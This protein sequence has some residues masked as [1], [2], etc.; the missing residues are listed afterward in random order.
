[1]ARK[2]SRLTAR[3]VASLKTP[4]RH[5]DGGN[6]Y[7][8]I[9]KTAGGL[10]KR[11]V[12]MFSLAGKQR[13]PG[14]GAFPAVNLAAARS[15]AKDMR[16][17]VDQGIDPLDQKKAASEAA[18]GRKTFAECAAS[19]IASKSSS[20]RNAKHAG[21]WETTLATHG[22]ALRDI[23]VDAIT[24]QDVLAVLTPIWQDIPET[25]SRLRGRIEAVLDFATAHGLR[26]EAN[27]AS[28]RTLQHILPKRAALSRGRHAALPYVDVPAFVAT[29]RG[30]DTIPAMAL[31]FLILTASRSGEV[32]GASWDEIDLAAKVWVIP[33]ARMK[34][35]REHRVPL[36]ARAIAI[37]EQLAAHRTCGFVFPG[38]NNQQLESTSLRRLC[39]AGITVHGFRSSFRDFLGDQTNFSRE[40]CEGCLAHSV[41]NS[42][43]RA[44]RRSDDLERRREAMTVWANF[45]EPGASAAN[46]VKLRQQSK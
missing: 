3:S 13:E 6:L 22:K 39:P 11:W 5:A 41:G 43:E 15:K 29:L 14:L 46:V 33:A 35:G 23:P 28:W 8:T 12:F 2:T 10:S 1:M 34:A 9:S 44:Y 17:M 27:P 32:L 31:E 37:L 4:G 45:C 25:A 21:Q 42:T 30:T 20:W 24:I 38:R 36:S 16:A 7:L 18:K 26:A 19:L 40:T